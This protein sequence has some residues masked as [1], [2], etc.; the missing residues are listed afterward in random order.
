VFHVFGYGSL[1]FSPELPD[2]VIDVRRAR[3]VGHRRAFNKR[4][5]SRS[6]EIGACF[7]APGPVPS[8]FTAGGRR[9]SI[10]LGTEP[11][12]DGR[13]QGL[14]ASY[15]DG[16]A[17]A[18]VRLLDLREGFDAARPGPLNG[19]LAAQVDVHTESGILTA[20]TYLS[21]LDPECRY[22]VTPAPDPQATAFILIHATPRRAGPPDAPRAP[23][24]EYLEGTRRS[25]RAVGIVDPY[26]ETVAAAVRAIPGPWVDRVAEPQ[27]Q[28]P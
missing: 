10:T 21:N 23:G 24:L 15:P 20:R 19:Y 6:V 17:A 22:S 25:L 28:G 14:V 27:G 1:T 4:S 5:R 11:A 8:E 16:V 3:L 12:P 7:D 26:L 2:A 9:L 18:L 13:I